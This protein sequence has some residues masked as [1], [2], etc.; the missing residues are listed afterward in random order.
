MAV[1]IT[2]SVQVFDDVDVSD[3]WETDCM[4]YLQLHYTPHNTAELFLLLG[5]SA[6]GC[7]GQGDTV[8][9]PS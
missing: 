5:S 4:T 6:L 8:S 9:L 1:A 7:L 3:C 2:W